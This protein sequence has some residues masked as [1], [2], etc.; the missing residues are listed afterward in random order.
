M[1]FRSGGVRTPEELRAQ[2]DEA[3]G[4]SKA[5]YA[6]HADDVAA[7]RKAHEETV[8]KLAEE[9]RAGRM[10]REEYERR[11]TELKG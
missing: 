11:I 4:K 10:T 1:L 7:A 6:A 5:Q 8:A 9:V 2:Y 3:L